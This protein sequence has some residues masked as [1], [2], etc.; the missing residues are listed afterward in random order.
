VK[1]NLDRELVTHAMTGSRNLSDCQLLEIVLRQRRKNAS[2][3]TF[4]IPD[5]H[6]NIYVRGCRCVRPGDVKEGV[7]GTVQDVVDLPRGRL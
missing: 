1:N 7:N 4:I 3:E 5:K 2:F 6:A